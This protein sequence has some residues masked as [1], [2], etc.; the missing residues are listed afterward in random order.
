M[1]KNLLSTSPFFFEERTLSM[2]D[3]G[4]RTEMRGASSDMLWNMFIKVVE[5]RK[6]FLV[7]YSPLDYLII[8]KSAFADDDELN[9]AKTLLKKNT[10]KYIEVS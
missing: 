8:P 7:L 3:N 10:S 4:I 5:S 6:A 2:D 1:L 9:L